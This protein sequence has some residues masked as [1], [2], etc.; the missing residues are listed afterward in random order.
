[1][2]PY[3]YQCS[4]PEPG[5]LTHGLEAAKC[6]RI[7][8]RSFLHRFPYGCLIPCL[9]SK[10]S[11]SERRRFMQEKVLKGGGD[12]LIRPSY[13]QKAS[14][15]TLYNEIWQHALDIMQYQCWIM[16][17]FL[18]QYKISQLSRLMHIVQIAGGMLISFAMS[19]CT[20]FDN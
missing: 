16:D 20:H 13:F 17:C 7:H 6:Y 12:T 8:V 14:W 10:V 15:A 11:V 5:R 4:V 3:C 18:K 19:V 9:R 1:M 2:H